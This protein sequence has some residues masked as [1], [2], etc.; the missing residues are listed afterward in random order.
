M[1]Y[2]VTQRVQEIGIRLALGGRPD[3]VLRL[4]VAE[5]L[6]MTLA[7]LALGLV[8]AA[9]LSRAMT[10]LLYGVTAVDPLTYGAIAVL[11]CLIA[12]G[13]SYIPAR[14]ATRIDPAVALRG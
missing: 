12:L 8:G 10:R 7:G 14:R 5:G 2:L 4:V 3:H 1:A 6:A 13:A 9:V 11:L